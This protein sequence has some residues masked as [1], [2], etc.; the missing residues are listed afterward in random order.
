MEPAHSHGRGDP[1][2][3]AKVTGPMAG[4]Y[5]AARHETDDREAQQEDHGGGDVRGSGEFRP[6]RMARSPFCEARQDGRHARRFRPQH[7]NRKRRQ[8]RSKH[9]QQQDADDGRR[10][11]GMTG[12][13]RPCS[14][15][16][17]ARQCGRFPTRSCSTEPPQKRLMIWRTA[18]AAT[19]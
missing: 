11:S 18:W 19:L 16:P 1:I 17:Q 5:Q 6:A 13:R 8:D 14:K 4:A 10:E 12:R 7:A 2:A 9:G 3:F 15:Q